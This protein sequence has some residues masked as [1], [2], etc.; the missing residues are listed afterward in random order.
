MTMRKRA[1]SI[2][3]AALAL[4]L[5]ILASIVSMSLAS[6][7]DA[8]LWGVI[9]WVILAGV[10]V[11]VVLGWRFGPRVG[12]WNPFVLIGWMGLSAVLLGDAEIVAGIAIGGLIDGRPEV[13]V[14]APLLYGL[15]LFVGLL[16]LPLTLAG[17]VLWFVVYAVFER[18]THRTAKG[19]GVAGASGVVSERLA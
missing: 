1:R 10:P 13:L 3:G 8:G 19:P 11:G 12:G 14:L 7:Y 2:A 18:L 15:G 16:V 6:A 4:Y 9:A 17:A 5:G